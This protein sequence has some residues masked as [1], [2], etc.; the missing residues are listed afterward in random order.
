MSVAPALKTAATTLINILFGSQTNPDK[1]K[2]SLVPFSQ[3][4]RVDTTIVYSPRRVATRASCRQ[5]DVRYGFAYSF[6]QNDQY[7]S[8]SRPVMGAPARV[9]GNAHRPSE[10]T[11]GPPKTRKVRREVADDP[12]EN[13]YASPAPGVGHACP[14]M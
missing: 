12:G 3:T 9:S 6:V 10:T 5:A 11:S 7:R 8:C 2:M 14:P 4:V 1:L 13:P